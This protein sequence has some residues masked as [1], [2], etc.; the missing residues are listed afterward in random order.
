VLAAI[1]SSLSDAS[2]PPL[3]FTGAVLLGIRKTYGP[4]T[5]FAALVRSESQLP[6][7]EE[8]GIKIVQGANQDHQLIADHLA[9]NSYDAVIQCADCDDLPYMNAI[10]AGMKK[11]YEATGKAGVLLHTR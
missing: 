2:S 11:R 9:K 5:H 1:P 7:F 10:L 6:L 4:E 8:L 3:S